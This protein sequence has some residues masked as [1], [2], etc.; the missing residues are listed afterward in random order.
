MARRSVLASP[1]LLPLAAGIHPAS[2]QPAGVVMDEMLIPGREPGM[3]LYLRNKRPEAQAPARPDRTILCVHGATYPASTTFDL[4]LSGV[5]WMDYMAGRGFD[6]W[7]LDLTGY[8][9]ST[10]PPA[11]QSPPP[12]RGEQAV[13]DI[14]VALKHIREA[15]GVAKTGLIGWSWG[16]TLVSRFA[17]DNP[18]LVD[19]LVL[20][21]PLWLRDPNKRGAVPVPEGPLPAYRTVTRAQA[22]ER[23]MNGVPDNKRANLIPPGWYEYWADATFATD[24]EGS[25]QVPSVLRAPNGVL[26]DLREHWDAGRPFYDPAKITVPA[27]LVL[28]EWDRDTP[29][30]MAT[31]LF[32]LLTNSPGKRLVMLAEGTHSIML[33][34]NRGAL[35]QAVQVFLEE[36]FA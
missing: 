19:R 30:S 23:W 25:R 3:Q 18:A 20:Y 21:A 33:E 24:P 22:R 35:F 12:T 31:T 14:A 28:G 16:T 1:M 6:V 11:D 27:L 17:A 9:R 29:P 32:P 13:A 10:R 7:S 34:R 8:G 26:Q 15:R 5:S 36:S 2:A 4:P